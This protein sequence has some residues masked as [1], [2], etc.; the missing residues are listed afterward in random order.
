MGFYVWVGWVG[1][2]LN[3]IYIRILIQDIFSFLTFEAYNITGNS[4]VQG[5]R[6]FQPVLWSGVSPQN[7][8]FHFVS[9]GLGCLSAKAFAFC[10]A[11]KVRSPAIFALRAQSINSFVRLVQLRKKKLS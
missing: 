5:A 8:D 7:G 10:Q 3:I 6:Y 2:V 9:P 4:K 11:V 1:V